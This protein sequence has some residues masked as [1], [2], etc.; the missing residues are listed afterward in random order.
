LEADRHLIAFLRGHAASSGDFVANADDARDQGTTEEGASD[1]YEQ[2]DDAPNVNSG[3][4]ESPPFVRPEV[5]DPSDD[6][7]PARPLDPTGDS[8]F[9]PRLYSPDDPP[10]FS[11]GSGDDASQDRPLDSGIPQAVFH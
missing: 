4:C 10:S 7:D 1:G 6:T 8:Q 11:N 3:N 5:V 9:V 2:A